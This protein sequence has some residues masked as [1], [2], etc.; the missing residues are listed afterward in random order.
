MTKPVNYTR[1]ASRWTRSVF[2]WNDHHAAIPVPSLD[3]G[4]T[5]R[6][7]EA[8]S[9]HTRRAVNDSFQSSPLVDAEMVYIRKDVLQNYMALEVLT[10][11]QGGTYV[12]IKA[13][14]CLSVPDNS[15]GA[16]LALQDTREEIHSVSNP[17]L[18]FSQWL[19]SWFV[20]WGM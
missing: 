7:P 18:S 19:S 20:S 9:D 17:D 10:P 5:V 1:L 3:F 16:P 12:I 13:Q 11:A 15:G 2:H 14:C 8:L 4:D 6:R